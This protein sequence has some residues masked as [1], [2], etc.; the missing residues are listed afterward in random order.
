MLKSNADKRHLLVSSSDAVSIIVS[1]YDI[2][3]VNVRNCYV[4]SLTI[5]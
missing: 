4:S 1:E 2:K 5:S 3:T